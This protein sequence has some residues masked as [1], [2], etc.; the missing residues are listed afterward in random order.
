MDKNAPGR[1]E[2]ILKVLIKRIKFICT[3]WV[4]K[5]HIKKKNTQKRQQ[6]CLCFKNSHYKPE[7]DKNKDQ[8][9]FLCA[10][11]SSYRP[12]NIQQG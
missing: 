1:P 8:R 9:T 7:K 2:N 10:K 4:K 11:K 5:F 6:N 12:E 3:S